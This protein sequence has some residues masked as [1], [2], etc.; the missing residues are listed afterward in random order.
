MCYTSATEVSMLSIEVT[1]LF[2]CI[3]KCIFIRCG[4]NGLV[5]NGNILHNIHVKHIICRARRVVELRNLRQTSRFLRN[6]HTCETEG[7]IRELTERHIHKLLD[8]INKS[9]NGDTTYT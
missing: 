8:R 7:D 9:R 1:T 6:I 3:L 2:T 4:S 5:A